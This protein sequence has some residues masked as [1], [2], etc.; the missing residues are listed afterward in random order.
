MA[1]SVCECPCHSSGPGIAGRRGPAARK[2]AW[3]HFTHGA[4]GPIEI[5]E[6]GSEL[7]RMPSFSQAGSRSHHT[8]LQSAG[9]GFLLSICFLRKAE[10]PSYWDTQLTPK[11]VSEPASASLRPTCWQ[12][13][14]QGGLELA[15]GG[16]GYVGA[17]RIPW[18]DTV[19]ER[20]GT[21]WLVWWQALS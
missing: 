5:A 17:K 21:L 12:H 18:L 16:V 20:G 7:S 8:V 14:V 15:D 13:G 3:F 1:L 11:R 10:V 9:S 6:S 2:A 19:C 4:A